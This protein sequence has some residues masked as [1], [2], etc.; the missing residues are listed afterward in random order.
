MQ[1]TW[2][3]LC[4]ESWQEWWHGGESLF[5]GFVG[6]SVCLPKVREVMTKDVV[7]AS[8]EM[9]VYEAVKLLSSKKVGGAP[10]VDEKG[11]LVGIVSESDIV[12]LLKRQAEAAKRL[13]PKRGRSIEPAARQILE[14]FSID[15]FW[16]LWNAHSMEA[17]FK[18]LMDSEA[19][20]NAKVGDI[21]TSKVRTVGAEED[22]EKA[23]ELMNR[24]DINRVPVV[25]ENDHLVG[26]VA[27]GDLLRGLADMNR[28]RS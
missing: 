7:V 21:M 11:R 14:F 18:N 10:V 13:K 3:E 16:Y 23:A 15:W 1:N 5:N 26:I 20:R 27:R 22:M 9:P 4:I 17:L 19:L 2:D 6:E 24:Y 12:R 8:A 28:R 25:D